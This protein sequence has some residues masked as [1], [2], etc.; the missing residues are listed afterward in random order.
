LVN[1][2]SSLAQQIETGVGD[3][4][5]P[6]QLPSRTLCQRAMGGEVEEDGVARASNALLQISERFE[7]CCPPGLLRAD[8]GAHVVELIEA[9]GE[10]ACVGRGE[11]QLGEL[12]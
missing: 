3:D 5:L 6:F 7:N 10:R 1:G 9:S 12:V 8:Q 4:Q 11:V 2:N